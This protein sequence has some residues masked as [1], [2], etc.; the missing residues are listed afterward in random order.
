MR[1]QWNEL[2]SAASSQ[3]LPDSNRARGLARRRD[4]NAAAISLA[5]SFVTQKVPRHALC[6]GG[7]YEL[8]P[9]S[10]IGFETIV[11]ADVQRDI[12]E[13]TARSWE[14]HRVS[15]SAKIFD[16]ASLSAESMSSWIGSTSACSSLE[17]LE[18]A[19]LETIDHLNDFN[20]WPVESGSFDLVISPVLMSSLPI[21]P[22]VAA[23]F[24]RMPEECV[25]E[26]GDFKVAT[27]M[28]SGAFFQNPRAIVFARSVWNFHL[29]EL[30]RVCGDSGIVIASEW[31]RPAGESSTRVG[32]FI[33][34][35][36]GAEEAVFSNAVPLMAASLRAYGDDRPS[37]V[38]LRV[39]KSDAIRSRFQ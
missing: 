35:S 22:F 15:A 30:A 16:A 23:A 29:R 21:S 7:G 6:L 33:L 38:E 14:S 5:S 25:D 18:T 4:L 12:A 36:E 9:Q 19:Y 3:I 32:D 10:L 11:L 39:L 34:P 24:S 2:Y 20:P 31:V 37:T 1:A 27:D 28:L 26:C 8:S 13:E 17:E